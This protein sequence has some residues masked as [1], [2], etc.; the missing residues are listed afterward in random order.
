MSLD[1]RSGFTRFRWTEGNA[2]LM[3]NT[4]A[5]VS[6]EEAELVIG[7]VRKL[8]NKRGTQCSRLIL[9]NSPPSWTDGRAVTAESVVP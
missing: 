7:S 4:L 9:G 3:M 6:K 5:E 1:S 2:Q 8:T